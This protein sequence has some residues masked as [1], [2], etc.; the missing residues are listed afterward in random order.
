VKKS[1]L[2]STDPIYISFVPTAVSW[3][4]FKKRL[5]NLGSTPKHSMSVCCR[6][7]E[8][9]LPKQRSKRRPAIGS[10]QD[11]F[12]LANGTGALG[13][14][15]HKSAILTGEPGDLLPGFR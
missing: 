14:T 1:T 15:V 13:L 4:F 9:F 11:L 2:G 10:V 7:F 6:H 3:L 8:F 5:L 12:R